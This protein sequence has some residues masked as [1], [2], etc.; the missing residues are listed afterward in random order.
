MI[1]VYS[2]ARELLEYIT[3]TISLIYFIFIFS[4]PDDRVKLSF[5]ASIRSRDMLN[6]LLSR[7]VTAEKGSLTASHFRDVS[8]YKDEG[9]MK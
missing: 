6:R 5:N 3:F 9:E 1:A 8:M 7:Q 2:P 4:Y